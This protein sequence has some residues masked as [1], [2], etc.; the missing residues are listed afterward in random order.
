MAMFSFAPDIDPVSMDFYWSCW[1]ADSGSAAWNLAGYCDPEFDD[2]VFELLSASTPED[3]LTASNL[4]QKKLNTEL[5]WLILAGENQMQAYN[6]DKFEF[7]E[8]LCQ[9][10]VGVWQFPQIMEVEAK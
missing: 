3:A 1:S 5:P 4:A 9:A 8:D 6:H 2:L 10:G 7:S